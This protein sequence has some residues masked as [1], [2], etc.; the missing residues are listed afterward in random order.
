MSRCDNDNLLQDVFLSSETLLENQAVRPS[1]IF[2][3]SIP[4]EL[5]SSMV[6]SSVLVLQDEITVG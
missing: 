5:D 3:P 2:V 4:S 1:N 6:D